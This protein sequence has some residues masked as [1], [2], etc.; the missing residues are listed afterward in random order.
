MLPS[1]RLVA[2][3]FFCG[4][5]MVFAGLRLASSLNDFHE[6]LPVM[7]AHAAPLSVG[8]P[9]GPDFT[10]GP[11]MMPSIYDLRFSMTP[12]GPTLVSAVSTQR[13]ELPAAPLSLAAPGVTNETLAVVPQAAVPDTPVETTPAPISKTD[14]Q[15]ANEHPP[16]DTPQIAPLAALTMQP[17]LPTVVVAPPVSA[18]VQL[19]EVIAAL[20]AQP[21]GK[22]FD[23]VAAEPLVPE[24][25]TTPTGS[26]ESSEQTGKS[27]DEPRSVN[28]VLPPTD[29][30]S[31]A[32]QDAKA[33]SDRPQPKKA[34]AVPHKKKTRVAHRATTPTAPDSNFT[35]NNTTSPFASPR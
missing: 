10:R 1:F 2:A 13:I 5:L 26:I 28:I 3:T 21:E 20:P 24:S 8:M 11:A 27:D 4:F 32:A 17:A 12:A 30:R 33:K 15:S 6:A 16:V 18:N 23:G 19:P 25:D 35:F 29:P 7:A 31:A 22:P 9:A 14:G 34:A